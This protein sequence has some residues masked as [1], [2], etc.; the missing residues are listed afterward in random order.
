VPFYCAAPS[1]TIDSGLADGE[2]IP[3]EQRAPEEVKVIA[4]RAV[5][6]PEASALNPAFD[7]TP[8]RYVSGFVT[9]R[10]F[11]K[12]PFGDGEGGGG[13]S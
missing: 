13:R 9:E 11:E 2:G 10:G 8:A 5:A 4:G 12:P 1:T 6:P 3:I 7:V